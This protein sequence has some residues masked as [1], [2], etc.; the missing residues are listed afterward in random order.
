M[1]NPID[2]LYC[3]YGITLMKN[4]VMYM[5]ILYIIY[6]LYICT[7]VYVYVHAHI[8]FTK[9]NGNWGKCWTESDGNIESTNKEWVIRWT[10][11]VIHARTF[12]L[13]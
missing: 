12:D 4:N 10:P 13:F 3:H 7:Y 2:S 1:V 11:E 9:R 6:M 8:N 5:Y